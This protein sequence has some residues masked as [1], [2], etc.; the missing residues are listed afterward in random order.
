PGD[1]VVQHADD[2]VV[3]GA[4]VL[5]HGVGGGLLL[6]GRVEQLPEALFDR[7]RSVP[8]P[9][10]F[11]LLGP[12]SALGVLAQAVVHAAAGDAPLVGLFAVPGGR[13]AGHRNASAT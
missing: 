3:A 13:F 6:G 11:A 1:E 5:G 4:L 12:G 9:R 7:F 8:A 2:R 10:L